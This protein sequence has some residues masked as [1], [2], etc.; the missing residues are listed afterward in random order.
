[1]N[2]NKL[3]KIKYY[4]AF[5]LLMLGLYVYAGLSGTRFIGSDASAWSPQQ[6][7]GHHK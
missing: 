7:K 4:L 2:R 3:L 5:V 1:M 6:E